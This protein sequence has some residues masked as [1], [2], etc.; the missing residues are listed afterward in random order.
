MKMRHSQAL[1][2]LGLSPNYLDNYYPNVCLWESSMILS[3]K[4]GIS[5]RNIV[6]ENSP[7][8][9]YRS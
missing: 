8:I 3:T 5:R 9:C 7:C 6:M 1:L 2:N 4:N